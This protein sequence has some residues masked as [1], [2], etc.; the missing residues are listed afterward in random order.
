MGLAV[1]RCRRPAH[2]LRLLPLDSLVLASSFAIYGLIRKKLALD[3][4][5]GLLIETMI[6][7]PPAPIYLW[8][9]ADSP[10]SHM[11]E[12]AGTSTCC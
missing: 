4:L 3:A 5:T 12:N 11:T 9:F 2:R 10:T 7:L 1:D 8:G 6:M